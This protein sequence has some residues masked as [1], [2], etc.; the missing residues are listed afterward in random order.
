MPPFKVIIFKMI[1]IAKI[2]WIKCLKFLNS[3]STTKCFVLFELLF[4][5]RFYR[6]S[7][8]PVF[9]TKLAFANLA[10]KFSA[11]SLLNSGVVIYL[12]RPWL[13]ILFSI[14]LIF[15]L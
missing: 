5:L 8:K 7:S 6:L 10:A 13:V 9:I 11:V 3:F 14:S 15:V 12:S 4:L 2:N 1:F